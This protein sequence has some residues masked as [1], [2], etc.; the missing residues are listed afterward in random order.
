MV[1]MKREI[2]V[3]D[4]PQ[5]LPRALYAVV[6]SSPNGSVIRGEATNSDFG[7]GG[8]AEALWV[9]DD[10]DEWQRVPPLYTAK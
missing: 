8:R 1:G 4:V 6:F 10:N 5:S 2:P 3:N 7:R 9:L